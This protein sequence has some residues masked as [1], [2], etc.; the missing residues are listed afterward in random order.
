MTNCASSSASLCRVC[1]RDRH[2]RVP[3]TVHALRQL[4]DQRQ[5]LAVGIDQ[6]QMAALQPLAA[7]QRRQRVQ[8][9]GIASGANCDDFVGSTCVP[10][11]SDDMR[12]PP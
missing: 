6:R 5:R 8:P 3:L 4:L 10:P 2:V 1:A 11:F 7:H 12:W 9:K